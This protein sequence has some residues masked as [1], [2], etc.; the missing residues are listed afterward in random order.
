MKELLCG[1]VRNCHKFAT[2]L[3]TVLTLIITTHEC[4]ST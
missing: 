2:V 4:S 1:Y 3:D